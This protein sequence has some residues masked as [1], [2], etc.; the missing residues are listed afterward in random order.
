MDKS[1]HVSKS[2]EIKATAETV[3][4]VLTEPAQIKQY[5]FGTEAESDWQEG[6]A[7]LFSGEYEGQQYHDKG[8]ILEHQEKKIL[9]Y[10]YWSGFSG[11]EDRPENY[12]QV[13]YS[14]NTLGENNYLF[15]WHQKGFVSA[16]ACEHTE[17]ALEGML[18]KIKELAEQP[19]LP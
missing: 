16:K 1:L 4:K 7:I 6:S 9:R 12:A 5:L 11:L 3:W 14:L 13:S 19:F 2:I 17:T 18:T 8:V 15:T 10:S